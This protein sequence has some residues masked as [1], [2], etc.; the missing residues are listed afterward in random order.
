MGATTSGVFLVAYVLAME[1][2]G[3][4]YRCHNC[5]SS[6]LLTSMARVLAGTLCQYYYTAGYLVMAG[7][8]YL[9]HD[10]WQ[11]L[12]IVLTLPSILFLSYWSGSLLPAPL[13]YC[14]SARWI[15]SESVRWQLTTGRYQEAKQQI[16][17]V[18]ARNKATLQEQLVDDM[19]SMAAAAVLVLLHKT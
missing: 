2:V 13:H 14:L 10:S 5:L 16:L 1:M 15:V 7:L 19:I 6:S 17:R 4:D 12:Q 18:A 8:A 3:P 9:L 11:L